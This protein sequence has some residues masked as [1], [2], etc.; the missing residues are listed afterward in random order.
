LAGGSAVEGLL[1]GAEAS[2]LLPMAGN[3]DFL[4]IFGEVEEMSE[5]IFGL[6]GAYFFHNK[7]FTFS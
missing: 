3:D 7:T 1:D 6:E 2:D 5:F 4:A